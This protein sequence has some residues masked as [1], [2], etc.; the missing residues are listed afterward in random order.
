MVMRAMTRIMMAAT[1][2]QTNPV[3]STHSASAGAVFV[4]MTISC[5]LPDSED[6]GSDD[7]FFRSARVGKSNWT[8]LGAITCAENIVV[9]LVVHF[10]I[11]FDF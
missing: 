9:E 10:A 8:S 3:A 7:D 5:G 4:L 1:A 11:S 6:S 2:A